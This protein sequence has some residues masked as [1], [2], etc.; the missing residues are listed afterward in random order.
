MTQ[1]P[2]ADCRKRKCKHYRGLQH[3][4]EIAIDT[5]SAFPEGIPL[6]IAISE[7]LHMTKYP[8]QK[9]DIIFED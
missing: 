4:G 2:P 5:C 1:I 7:N 8:G 9:N 6:K 3:V